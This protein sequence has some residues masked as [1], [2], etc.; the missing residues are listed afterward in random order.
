MPE[1]RKVLL[2][3]RV[4]GLLALSSYLERP[5]SK[6]SKASCVFMRAGPPL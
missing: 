5:T 4:T 1:F 2:L 6:L 3:T